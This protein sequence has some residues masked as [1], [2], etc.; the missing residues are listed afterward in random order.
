MSGRKATA[1]RRSPLPDSPE[2]YEE[3]GPMKQVTHRMAA[4]VPA[5]GGARPQSGRGIC[6]NPWHIGDTRARIDRN[7]FAYVDVAITESKLHFRWPGD[8]SS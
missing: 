4:A 5:A 2:T 7:V 3:T 6:A 1:P 8:P